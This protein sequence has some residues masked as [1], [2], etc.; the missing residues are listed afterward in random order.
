[1]SVLLGRIQSYE[2]QLQSADQTF[3]DTAEFCRK[4][5][6]DNTYGLT[7]LYW[8]WA[9]ANKLS[10]NEE[11]YARHF[12][13]TAEYNLKRHETPAMFLKESINIFTCTLRQRCTTR[14]ARGPHQRQKGT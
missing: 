7:D 12:K 4:K 9:L 5:S 10:G 14:L 13:M 3:A 8:R 2:G 6:Y 11:G 1:M